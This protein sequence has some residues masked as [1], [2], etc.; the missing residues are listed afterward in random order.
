MSGNSSRGS[1]LSLDLPHTSDAVSLVCAPTARG[2][3]YFRQA[4]VLPKM[5]EIFDLPQ[6]NQLEKTLFFPSP[7]SGVARK[8]GKFNNEAYYGDNV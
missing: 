1:G 3:K 2:S 8:P 6:A 5:I 7:F 4:H